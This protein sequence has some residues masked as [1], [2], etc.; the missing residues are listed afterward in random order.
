MTNAEYLDQPFPWS[1]VAFLERACLAQRIE[2]QQETPFPGEAAVRKMREGYE[3]R[4]LTNLRALSRDQREAML[5]EVLARRTNLSRTAWQKNGETPRNLETDFA[6][7]LLSQLLTY[8]KEE[9]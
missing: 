2:K 1:L 7:P 3:R 8:P 5:I 6:E 4:Y 9:V